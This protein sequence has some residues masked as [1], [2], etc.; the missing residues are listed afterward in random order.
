MQTLGPLCPLSR[1]AETSTHVSKHR[2]LALGWMLRT[3][4]NWTEC[5]LPR[6]SQCKPGLAYLPEPLLPAT[7][8][9][10]TPGPDSWTVG[11]C[12]FC[13]LSHPLLSS[14]FLEPAGPPPR[15]A[16]PHEVRGQAPAQAVHDVEEQEAADGVEELTWE[17]ERGSPWSPLPSPCSP[18]R[19][20]A[21]P[22]SASQHSLHFPGLV[23]LVTMAVMAGKTDRVTVKTN[24]RYSAVSQ[25][26]EP[27]AGV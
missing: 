18:L 12:P 16:H 11:K 13:A 8:C 1:G 10:S 14:R 21:Q 27:E 17:R 22:S 25:I 9:L 20:P 24:T 3:R 2:G 26:W 7:W 23:E 15:C 19:S 5:P 6:S 4:V